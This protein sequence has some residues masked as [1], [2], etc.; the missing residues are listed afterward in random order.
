MVSRRTGELK[1]SLLSALAAMV[2]ALVPSLVVLPA[3]AASPSGSATPSDTARDT[4][5]KAGKTEGKRAK[6]PRAAKGQKTGGKQEAK[7]HEAPRKP[8]EA[9]ADAK[10]KASQGSA[11]SP[12]G[13]KTKKT[14]SRGVSARAKKAKKAD[15]E[16]PQ[17]PCFGPSVTVDRGGLEGSAFP[18]LDC[19][20]AP[21][22][23][24]R[25]ELSL[26]ARPWSVARPGHYRKA[27]ADP[28]AT[29]TEKLAK[30]GGKGKG[31]AKRAADANEIA[32][33]V[34][35]LDPG[36]LTRLDAVSRKFSN[37]PISLVSGYRPQS[38]GS[39]H[40]SGRALD[41][42]VAGVSNEELSAF[43]KT[44]TDTGCGYYP[45]SS[46]VHIDVRNPGTGGV[47]WIDASGPGEA[48]RYVKQ[49]PPPDELLPVPSHAAAT[50]AEP[51]DSAADPWQLD[52]DSTDADED[53]DSATEGSEAPA[54]KT[55]S[56]PLS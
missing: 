55:P 31:K 47:S 56:P 2:A 52:L 41:L 21:L 49:W 33:G 19:H 34:R 3:E 29:G 38:R 42:R 53:P 6:K 43:C 5:G 46:F 35:L 4:Q 30:R 10:A 7:A 48:P 45:N 12:K 11:A 50:D 14:A 22:P 16:A 13:K 17:K 39:Q 9:Q 40:Q 32:P 36:L 18:L 8:D 23:A 37:K 54:A 24:S 15:A 51:H 1:R 28:R 44:L 27:D 20:G 25:A 26:L